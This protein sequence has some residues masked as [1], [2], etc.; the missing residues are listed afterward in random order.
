MAIAIRAM[1]SALP[2]QGG[3]K[4]SVLTGNEILEMLLG[5]KKYPLK[6]FTPKKFKRLQSFIR[7]LENATGIETRNVLNDKSIK[8][9]N[10]Y[11]ALA[12]GRKTLE[13]AGIHP[14]KVQGFVYASDT[15][16]F[17]FPS[18]GIAVAQLL[19]IKPKQFNNTSM[20][21]VSIAEA[22]SNACSWLEQGLCENVLVLA[23]D[24]TTRLQLPKNRIEP[25]IFGDGFVGI[26]LDK[27]K[28]TENGSH[29]ERGGFTFTNISVDTSQSDLFV[30]RHIYPSELGFFNGA[31]M[32][33]GQDNDTGLDALGDI[34]SVELA[35][36]LRDFLENT[37]SVLDDS[38]KIILPQ[39]G[40][41]VRKK[42]VKHFQ[43]ETGVNIERNVVPNNSFKRHGNIGA[44]AVPLAWQEG[45]ESGDI[46]PEHSVVF[47][48]AGVGGVKTVF[49]YDPNTTGISFVENIRSSVRPD[50][51]R[52]IVEKAMEQLTRVQKRRVTNGKTL[53]RLNLE[54][55][56][57]DHIGFSPVHREIN[58]KT[59][60]NVSEEKREQELGSTARAESA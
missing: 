30:H 26:Y 53:N 18:P 4:G 34:D 32:E 3:L 10:T 20:A 27:K 23:G 19:E 48:I 43:D 2:G 16:D 55:N 50:Y 24:V 46:K 33:N 14:S 41:L 29:E 5:L 42:G 6:W 45:L 60:A 54:R 31:L 51:R 1:S 13:K 52:M 57:H 47:D 28:S 12:A 56:G 40:N 17:V 38:T 39:T 44:G 25:F 37:G 21:C 35:L 11:L 7:R 49:K 36:L 8:Y 9:P 59:P 58:S 22:L 15:P